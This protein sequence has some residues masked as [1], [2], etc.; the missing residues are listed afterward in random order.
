MKN[1]TK[2]ALIIAAQAEKPSVAK[3]ETKIEIHLIPL[4]S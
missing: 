4:T 3:H 1:H 2:K